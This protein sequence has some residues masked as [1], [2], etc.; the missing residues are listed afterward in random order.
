MEECIALYDFDGGE[1]EL[2]FK[3]NDTIFVK[4]KGCDSGW[5]SGIGPDGMQGDFP[6]ILVSSDMRR[7]AP[8]AWTD[9]CV[10]LY[11][12]GGNDQGEE[13]RFARHDV[14]HVVRDCPESLGWWWGRNETRG[15]QQV[16]MFPA[17]FV[18][19]NVVKALYRFA[20]RTPNEITFNK[21]DVIV[22]KRRWNDGWWE[23]QVHDR[24]GIFPA[25]YTVSN[26][27]TLPKPL[28]CS[29]ERE[30]F[31]VGATECHVCAANEEIVASMLATLDSWAESGKPQSQL[32]L[33]ER[34][35]VEPGGEK[36]SLLRPCD[37]EPSTRQLTQPILEKGAPGGAP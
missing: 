7:S 6:N 12:Y 27:S 17:N 20:A 26:V 18:T 33:F 10:A 29:V 35:Q 14:I 31:K 5:W 13:M 36:A 22:V 4:A 11:D 21:G 24:Q 3:E 2:S 28:F 25:N 15:E 1:G 16:K 9:R 34:V 8:P 23:G 37:L 32:N 19:A 30:I